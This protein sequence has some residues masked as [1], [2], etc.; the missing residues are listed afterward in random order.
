MFAGNAWA[1]TLYNDMCEVETQ[2]ACHSFKPKMRNHK[3]YANQEEQLWI[4]ILQTELRTHHEQRKNTHSIDK[5]S[6]E[7]KC[8]SAMKISFETFIKLK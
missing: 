1:T 7:N 3:A 4:C 6:S 5:I 8:D 2:L